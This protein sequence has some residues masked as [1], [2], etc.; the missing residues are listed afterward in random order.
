MGK[1]IFKAA[2]TA[3]A[4]AAALALGFILFLTIS[5]FR[6]AEV[7]AVA[8][9]SYAEPEG[10]ADGSLTLM[11]WNI[12][13]CGM[14]AD[15][16]FVM[17][18]GAGSGKPE[19]REVLTGYYEGVLDTM[20]ANEADIYLLQEVDSDSSRSYGLD[21]SRGIPES[22]QLASGAYALN[23]SCPFVPFP[24]PP[25]GKVNSGI[26][27]ASSLVMEPEAERISL[28]CPFSWPLRTANLKRCLL[29]TRYD[30]PDTDAQLV[31]VNLH[32]EA[33]DDGEGKAEQT[34]ALI[35]LLER[36]YAAGNY[37]VAGGDFN[38]TFDGAMERWPMLSEDYW[39][40]SALS[41][42]E[43]P[44]GWSFAYDVERPSCRLD[45]AP[46]DPRTS[47]HYVLDG[48]IV[49]PNVAVESVRTLETG[50]EYSDHSPV[51]LEISL[52]EV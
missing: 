16:D 30:L 7:E 15:A 35:E 32:L 23:Y 24:W 44:E 8:V 31:A 22:L 19:T 43:L 6:P 25:I 11:S 9:E 40:P 28:P 21:E 51:M 20:R 29:V 27:T 38:Q 46:Y 34:A 45:N 1:R 36:E 5:E 10:F 52:L 12:G 50:F 17:D 47:Q 37:V 18:G 3:L 39:T 48:F 33:Y 4:L 49:S 42:D 26:L 2:L 13:Y 41:A 14:G